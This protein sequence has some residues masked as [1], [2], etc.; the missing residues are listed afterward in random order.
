MVSKLAETRLQERGPGESLKRKRWDHTE[1]AARP[2]PVNYGASE[3][4]ERLRKL[5]STGEGLK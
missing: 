1:P 5:R 2:V 4:G 3:Y